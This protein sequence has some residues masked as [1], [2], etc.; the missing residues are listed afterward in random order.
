MLRP[1]KRRQ[2]N[3]GLV[4]G[5]SGADAYSPDDPAP[6]APRRGVGRPLPPGAPAGSGRT[7]PGHVGHRLKPGLKVADNGAPI[8][9]GPPYRDEGLP[10]LIGMPVAL[11]P[12]HILAA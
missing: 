2:P 12:P 4:A 3:G 5:P 1:E 7:A 6:R 10:R 11:N 9:F 8:Q